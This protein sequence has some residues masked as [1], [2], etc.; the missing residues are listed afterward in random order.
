MLPFMLF[1]TLFSPIFTEPEEPLWICSSSDANISY[2]YCDNKKFPIS[3]NI[4]PCLTLKGSSGSLHIFFI[5]RRD[6]KKLYFNLHI[7]FHSMKLPMRKEVICR[8]Y[9]DEYSFCRALKGESVNATIAFSFK[10]IRFAKGRYNCVAE[11]ITGDIEER[12]FCL[13]F[14]IEH[15]PHLN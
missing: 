15:L 1:S 11:A 8:G 13:N 7:S 4:I 3:I 2:T 5:P 6:L 14:T 10:G 9:D 12:L